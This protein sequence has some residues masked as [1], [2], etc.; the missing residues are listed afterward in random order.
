MSGTSAH[1]LRKCRGRGGGAR[2]RGRAPLQGARAGGANDPCH[3][4]PG[5]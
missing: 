1:L 3:L 2:C 4:K 5:L